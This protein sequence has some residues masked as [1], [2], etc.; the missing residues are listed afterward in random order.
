[1]RRLQVLTT[2]LLLAACSDSPLEPSFKSP[3]R[4]D[5][6]DR[7]ISGVTWTTSST[8]VEMIDMGR[9]R[10]DNVDLS[11]YPV[12]IN[13]AGQVVGYYYMPTGNAR[14]F[15][16]ENGVYTDLG[17]LGGAVAVAQQISNDGVIV[18]YSYNADGK[19]R[20]A[21]WRSGVISQLPAPTGQET[22]TSLSGSAR[23]I[24][25][26]GDI[27]GHYGNN[28]VK[29][30]SAGAQI[31]G[32]FDGEERSEAYGINA[33]GLVIG[34][35]FTTG[36][37]VHKNWNWSGSIMSAQPF[38]DAH[39]LAALAAESGQILNDAGH[40]V[41]STTD[42]NWN[43][44]AF[45]YRDGAVQLLPHASADMN[46]GFAAALGLNEAGDVAGVD[47]A[48]DW[49]WRAV[50]WPRNGAA[51]DLGLAPG[52]FM[53]RASGVN[54]GVYAV[55][56]SIDASDNVSGVIWRWVGDRTTPM[57]SGSVQ[58]TFGANGWYVSDVNVT[59]TLH[60]DES[61]IKSSS[62]CEA[63]S[64]ALDAQSQSVTC[65]AT[66][67]VNMTE[68]ANVTFKRDATPPS[69]VYDNVGSYTVDQ[70]IAIT[71]TA[72]DAT[73]GVAS[74]TCQPINGEALSFGL[75]SHTFSASA[76]DNAG[77]TA[78]A[79]AT[80]SVT[81]TL[82]SLAVLTRRYSTS[83]QIG[84]MLARLLYGA[85][86]LRLNRNTLAAELALR[87]Y[88]LTVQAQSGKA[89]SAEHATLLLELSKSFIDTRDSRQKPKGKPRGW[90]RGR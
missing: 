53:S 5:S 61:G 59:W 58:G 47:L 77:L 72:A 41:G 23:S 22:N 37:F 8:N 12:S 49:T 30:T 71:C 74:H 25:A 87:A 1:M 39:E 60:D 14:A 70:T 45:V 6:P 52:G 67:G 68:S 36:S 89:F 64:F 76:T 32:V 63:A 35:T 65:S 19:R 29:W 42:E 73:S 44:R 48:A 54:N 16:W 81:V 28:A 9:F 79:S 40:V 2:A 27:V 10:R 33:G 15:L 31:I 38:S 85:E 34:T 43:T 3:I 66:N 82:G 20:P 50:I 88:V 55:G 86:H 13:D 18:G 7:F 56:Q 51:V 78:T 21:V 17:T 80:F 62:G 11:T 75:G 4:A 46:D 57:I 69:V 90:G 26:N 84:E 83:E 24:N